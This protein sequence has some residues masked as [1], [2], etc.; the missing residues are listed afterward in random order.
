M[1]QR[2][3]GIIG[4]GAI[5]KIL[6]AHLGNIGCEVYAI[7]IKK[8]IVDAINKNG[9][10]ITGK[11]ELHSRITKAFTSIE[12][13]YK[14]DLHYIFLCLKSWVLPEI[15]EQLKQFN[16][17]K[18]SLV[19]FQNGLDTEAVLIPIMP[20]EKVFRVVVNYAGVITI[21]GSVKMTFFHPPN[22]IGC[23]E[24]AGNK[25]I[26]TAKEIA[27]LLTESGLETEY[28]SNIKEKV[29]RKTILN[30]CM[31]PTSV[32][33]HLTMAQIMGLPETKEI[34]V[35]KLRE[36]LD[37]AK[38][39]GIIFEDDFMDKAIAYL[40]NAGDHK[41]SMLVDFEEGNKLEIDFL[42]GKIQEYADKHGISCPANK[43]ALSLI[44]GMLL[45]REVSS[46]KQDK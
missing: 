36:C 31:M 25:A 29:W 15:L 1:N 28:V 4:T 23:L 46:K 24:G 45:K 8:N 17:G 42:N 43:L 33:T 41:T 35:T 38:A 22:Y 7:D 30:S 5:G 10:H 40:T 26:E 2:K 11:E 18:S 20:Q 21:P 9:L 6:A 32:I 39:E 44:K 37:V 27:L 34:I 3:I 12:H 13:L 14:L 19:S 16:N